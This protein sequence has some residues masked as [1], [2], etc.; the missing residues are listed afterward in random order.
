MNQSVQEF[1]RYVKNT[2]FGKNPLS[3][4]QAAFYQRFNSEILSLC[5]SMPESVQTDSLLFLMRYSGLRP[6]EIP[7]FFANYYPPIW[8]IIF[9]LGNRHPTSGHLLAHQAISS[10]VKAQSMAMFL[11]S[12]DD[13]MIDQQISASLVTLQLRTQAWMIMDNAFCDLSGGDPAAN[14]AV[15]RFINDYYCAG[16]NL[17]TP[18]NLDSYCDLFRKQMAILMIPPVLLSLKIAGTSDF[19]RDIEVAYGSF[20]V[21]W[22]LLDDVRD[23]EEDI[24]KGAVTS[25]YLSLPERLRSYW[26]NSGARATSGTIKQ[27]ILSY[28]SENNV[29]CDIKRRICSELSQA[30]KIAET[31]D[32][33][34]LALQFRS[35]AHPLQVS[36]SD[37]DQCH[38]GSRTTTPQK[39]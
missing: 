2:D 37:Q 30:A 18:E 32:L 3:E 16:Q 7:D 26:K 39:C 31:H 1:L 9:W 13:H 8:S 4:R 25:V 34:G 38:G 22:R 17:K 12:L 28:L 23:I 5:R 15:G 33:S 36:G 11:H 6:G 14:S 29:I 20:G 19:T 35:L 27:D 24:E 21:A 10:A